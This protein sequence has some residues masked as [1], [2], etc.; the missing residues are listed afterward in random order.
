MG[1]IRKKKVKQ[2]HF[3]EEC[4]DNGDEADKSDNNEF[5]N[6]RELSCI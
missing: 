6:K 5:G 1:P 4:V 3:Q 2:V